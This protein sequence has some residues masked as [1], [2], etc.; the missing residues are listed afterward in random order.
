MK[1]HNMSISVIIP[2]YNSSISI[3]KALDSVYSQTDKGLSF[4]EDVIVVDDGSTD[5]SLS[6]LK[7]YKANNDLTNLTIISQ[8]N[9]GPSAARNRAIRES[10][11]EW[12]ALLDSDDSWRPDKVETQMRLAKSFENAR[13][14]ATASSKVTSRQGKRVSSDIYRYGILSYFM[15]SRVGTSGV[16]MRRSDVLEAG[17]FNEGMRYAEDQNLFMRLIALSGVYFINLP[18]VNISD[19]PVYGHSGLSANLSGMH[20]GVLLN[21]RQARCKG[22]IS[23]AQAMVALCTEYFKYGVRLIKTSTRGLLK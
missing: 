18:L 11:S 1:V 7:E 4:I 17:L 8:P 20:K 5:G 9:A 3:I 14:I 2:C 13:F 15:L 10:T 22:Y 23:G 16:L 19:K 6:L 21:I 12:V